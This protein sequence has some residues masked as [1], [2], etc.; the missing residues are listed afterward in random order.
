MPLPVRG[1]HVVATLRWNDV[2]GVYNLFGGPEQH[3][4]RGEEGGR[5]IA[6]DLDGRP[7][8][9]RCREWL[10]VE[11]LGPMSAPVPSS[12]EQALTEIRRCLGP[13]RP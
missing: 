7:A 11:E 8:W 13:K 10:T 1:Q 9:V 2:H 5:P 6:L 3:V 4:V 12:W